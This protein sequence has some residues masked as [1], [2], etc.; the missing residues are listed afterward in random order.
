ML[1]MS[2]V[3]ID[4]FLPIFANTGVPVA[5]LVPTPTGYEKSI[6][7]AT[8]PVRDLL[9]NSHVHDYD[10]QLQGPANKNIVKTYFVTGGNLIESA[11]SLYRPITKKETLAFGSQISRNT[12]LLATCLQLSLLIKNCMY[13][14][15]LTLRFHAL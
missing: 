15:F 4:R 13:S 1:A 2:D 10:A 11:A 14:I 9:F 12:V 8:A 5:F 7:D 3:N 6:M